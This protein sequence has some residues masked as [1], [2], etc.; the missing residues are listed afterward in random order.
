MGRDASDPSA[1]LGSDVEPDGGI[2]RLLRFHSTT[3][4]VNRAG[5]LQGMHRSF[6]LNKEK[7]Q[8]K[9]TDLAAHLLVY[10][11]LCES[12]ATERSARS[13]AARQY[14][15]TWNRDAEKKE[16]GRDK[17]SKCDHGRNASGAHRAGQRFSGPSWTFPYQQ[18]KATTTRLPP[19]FLE[20]TESHHEQQ[21][22]T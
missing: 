12:R 7:T 3:E 4:G 21:Q 22:L 14:R 8:I 20:T 9:E 6:Q 18:P 13:E 11:H 15:K 16:R 1:G 17:P 5:E 2:W 19:F 10:I